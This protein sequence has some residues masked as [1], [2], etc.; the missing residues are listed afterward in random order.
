[1]LYSIYSSSFFRVLVAVGALV[2]IYDVV[3]SIESFF[4]VKAIHQY[5]DDSYIYH[6]LF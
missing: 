2:S 4:G 1:M 3:A 6:L 5:S